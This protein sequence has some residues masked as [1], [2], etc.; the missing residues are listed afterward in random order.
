MTG[1]IALAARGLSVRQLSLAALLSLLCAAG[2][3]QYLRAQEGASSASAS[4]TGASRDGLAGL[5][6]AARASISAALGAEEP[7]YHFDVAP[8]GF[9]A[10]NPAEH[11]GIGIA[12]SGALLRSRSL[13]LGLSLRAVGY[14][15]SLSAVGAV[16]PSSEA[17][18]A[19]F[20]RAAIDEWYVNGPLGLEQG[21]TLTH[22]PAHGAAG[23]LTLAIALSGNARASLAAGGQ[24][25]T[26]S[27][28]RGGSLR[29]GGLSVS[30][31]SGR[32]LHSWM[33]LEGGELLLRVDADGAR[34]PLRIDPIV[35]KPE[36]KLAPSGEE[37]EHA[38]LSVALA[39][40][41]NTA[42]VGAP[43]EGP[44]GGVVWV[45]ERSGSEWVRSPEPIAIPVAEGEA[46]ECVEDPEGEAG[47]EGNECGFGRSVALS[48]DGET[49]LIGAPR[50]DVQVGAPSE[51]EAIVQAGAAW[52]FTHTGSGW[53]GTELTSPKPDRGGRFGRSVALAANGETALVGAP[54]ENGGH[55]QAW[56]F[57][58]SGSSWAAQGGAL[59]G[60]GEEG[61]GRFGASVALSGDGE[62]ALIGGP[63][64]DRSVGAAWVFQRQRSGPM[65]I[66]QGPKLT[67]GGESS[68]GHFGYSVALSEDG[69]TALVGA[70][71]VDDGTGAAWVFEQSGST[72]G[73]PGSKLVGEGEAGE[74][75][76]YSVALSASGNSAIVGA[77]HF[78]AGRG[79]AWLYERSGTGWSAAARKL[80]GGGKELDR[81]RF[82]S[83]VAMSPDDGE[84]VLVGGPGESGKSGTA[85]VFG[86]GPSVECVESVGSHECE[87]G[88]EYELA[89]GSTLGGTEVKI[90][91]AHLKGA[92]AVRFGVSEA[93]SFEV[94]AAGPEG[95]EDWITAVSPEGTGTV[96]VTV[97]TPFGTSAEDEHDQFMYVPPAHKKSKKEPEPPPPG[98]APNGSPNGGTF[99]GTGATQAV[100]A[101]GPI[102]GGACGASLISKK[103]A[104]QPNHRALFRLL[105]TGAG[106]CG[107]KL[108]LRVKIKLA[109]R[110]FKLKTIGTAVF[111]ISAGKR[112]SVSVKLNAAGRALLKAGHGRLNASLLLV[113]QS[114]VPFV[115]HTASVRLA[116]QR[117]KPKTKAK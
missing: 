27:G 110:R 37:G 24:S 2:L 30:D 59:A 46:T 23:P 15:S 99:G 20:A 72:W 114:P 6:P 34:F 32:V 64:D 60:S 45:F 28:A 100:L 63:N 40:D 62:V 13:E 12:R 68:E 9:H 102:S 93:A 103:I 81:A 113:K 57:T 97:E 90:A 112:V 107:G 10:T 56:V 71:R 70:R 74:Q 42:L 111:S 50:V 82:G 58:G 77:P 115:S 75:F 22:P 47:E 7:A 17:N 25:V 84:T 86:P 94:H 52:V 18:R 19:T 73:Q 61:E 104:V 87:P 29:Y 16:Q 49:A 83:S 48:A 8:G 14:G 31:A 106:K 85:W 78:E 43:N 26:F 108:R 65:W 11:L 38:G 53:T 55:G 116:P 1:R 109:H 66:E 98:G 95:S 54:G 67:D 51:P 69:S 79:A 88:S 91:G 33:A 80:E 21:F 89:K 39:A 76:G 3:G 92:T 105:G 96:N 35:E 4:A 5:P 36:A 117:R 41:G 44:A 101:A